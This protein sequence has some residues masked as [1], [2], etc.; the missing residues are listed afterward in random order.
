MLKEKLKAIQVRDVM[1]NKVITVKE[2]DD[3]ALVNEKMDLYDIRHLP[4]VDDK[5][6]L[7]GLITQRDLYKIHSPRRLED[8][9]WFY[10]KDA[11]NGFILSA[12]MLRNV[13]TISPE[14]SLYQAVD[15]MV[16]LK[17]GCLI[18]IN[19]FKKPVG[20]ITRVDVLKFFLI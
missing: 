11:L 15:N 1:S 7:V 18:V 6:N 2:S 17:V 16:N 3:F 8:G 20:I 19:A 14:A 12:V 10:D 9:S 5:G 13:L 4:V